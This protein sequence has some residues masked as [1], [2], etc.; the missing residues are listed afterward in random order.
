MGFLLGAEVLSAGSGA[1]AS[2][3][4]TGVAARLETALVTGLAANAV[5]P[6]P[7]RPGAGVDEGTNG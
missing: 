4:L 3:A 2:E 1:L 7:L 6:G 5:T